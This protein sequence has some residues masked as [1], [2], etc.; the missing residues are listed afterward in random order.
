LIRNVFDHIMRNPESA[1]IDK[2]NTPGK[3]TFGEILSLSFREAVSWL[4]DELGE[5]PDQWQWGSLHHLTISHPLA[6]EKILDKI[7]GLSQGPYPVSGSFHTI[8]N[9]SYGFHNPFAVV[10]GASQRHIFDL[11]DWS[12]NHMIIPTGISGVPA[13]K[14]YV[15]QIETFVNDGYFRQDWRKDDVVANA[16]YTAILAPAR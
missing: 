9:Y 13:S 15:N 12:D 11:A 6:S 5:N 3:E 10:H 1:W 8:T 2:V 7:F 14:Y 16:K 4:E